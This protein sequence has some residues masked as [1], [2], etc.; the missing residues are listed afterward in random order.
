MGRGEHDAR[1]S[2]TPTGNNLL[3]IIKHC[4]NF[5]AGCFGPTFGVSSR[6]PSN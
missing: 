6:R 4:L 5:E 3:A 1:L 2:R